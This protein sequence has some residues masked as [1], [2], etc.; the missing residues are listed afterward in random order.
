M[1][2]TA[3]FT[4]LSSNVIGSDKVGREVNVQPEVPVEG[5]YGSSGFY[6]QV[7]DQRKL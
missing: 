7:F 6:F 5:I 3:E 4:K 2:R 1:P